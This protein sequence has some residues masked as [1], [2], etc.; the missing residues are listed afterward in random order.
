MSK[1]L[2][3]RITTALT[4]ATMALSMQTAL[5]AAAAPE[6]GQAANLNATSGNE[7]TSLGTITQNNIVYEIFD[8]NE[9]YVMDALRRLAELGALGR[10]VRFVLQHDALSWLFHDAGL[11]VAEEQGR[12]GRAVVDELARLGADVDDLARLDDDHA[13]A[14]VDGDDRA[15]GDDVALA[16]DVGAASLVGRTLLAFDRQRVLVEGIAIEE[17]TPRVGQ[18]SACC[19]HSCLNKTHNRS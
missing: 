2:S 4:A 13:L 9:A 7:K 6:A 5:N 18:D 8:G 19:A 17:V 14:V 1:K 11:E 3:A 12:L 10:G 15:V 16:A